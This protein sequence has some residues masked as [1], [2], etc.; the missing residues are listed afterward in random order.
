MARD[1]S[2]LLGKHRL[3]AVYA[4]ARHPFNPNC[5]AIAIDLD[6]RVVLFI[7]DTND[8]YR[9]SLGE[10]LVGD[11]TE[12]WPGTTIERDVVV[13]LRE[14]G[15]SG[16]DQVYEF[17]D[18]ETGKLGLEIGTSNIDDYYP[19]FVAHYHAEAWGERE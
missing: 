1:L 12:F 19:S 11:R 3:N 10:V 15:D 18:A 2:W 16:P 8:E 7:E 9:S 14:H 13:S 4:D 17:R 6:G 5:E